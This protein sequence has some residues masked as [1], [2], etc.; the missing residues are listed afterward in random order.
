MAEINEKQELINTYTN[1]I[2][3]WLYKLD[4]AEERGL[5]L[6]E[7]HDRLTKSVEFFDEQVSEIIDEEGDDDLFLEDFTNA[8]N[9]WWN[10]G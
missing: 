6:D 7:L 9:M 5:I 2:F 1:T 10:N 3:A 4:N 8:V